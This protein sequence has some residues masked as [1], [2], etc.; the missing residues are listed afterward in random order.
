[1]K[2]P[3]VS[4]VI[5]AYNHEKYVGE[6][7]QS[8]LDQTFRDFELIIINDGSTDNTEAEIF[9]FKDERIRYYSQENRG[10]NATLN[11]GIELAR[12][13]YFNFL[14]SDDAFLPE[15]LATQL[16]ALEE[17]RDIGIVFSYQIVIDGEGKEVKD[18][19]ILD[20]FTVPFETKE[21]IFPALFERDF[22][23]VPTALI[24]MEC[25]NRVG[26]FDESLRTTQDY[27]LWMRILRYYNIRLIKE[28]LLKLRW[29]GANLTYRTTPETELE[30]AKVLLKAYKNLNI[31]DIFPSLHYRK[32]SL[33]YA[34]AYEKLATYMEK[35]GVPSLLLISQIYREKGRSLKE[36]EG[37]FAVLRALSRE[38]ETE[39]VPVERGKGKIGV[40]VEAPSL[41][42]GGMEEV[43]YNIATHLTS[44]LFHVV[45]VC[46]ERGGHVEGRL[47]KSGIPVEILGEQKEK[48]YL[49]ILHRYRIDLVNTHYSH[50]GPPIAYREGIPVISFIHSIYNWV[51][52]SIFDDFRSVDPYVS[53]YIAVS[54]VAEEYA[55]YRF[56]IDKGKILF[57]PDGIDVKRFPDGKGPP[58]LTRKDFWNE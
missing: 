43:V 16:K 39:I 45:V 31:E 25:F 30:R 40:L 24:K 5:P 42:R 8:V 13:E 51:S 7:I 56:N 46:V 1:M 27:D 23:S 49:E 36:G 55:R 37:D 26:L 44:D 19:P 35:S 38:E 47:R 54:R 53:K 20:W 14:P 29:H 28:P 21:E 50:F 15:K 9:K 32:D 11:R 4:V 33:A 2:N 48:E 34:E 22:L 57:I 3:K 18:D 52:N 41:D 10:L 17:S 6:A 58:T 12:G